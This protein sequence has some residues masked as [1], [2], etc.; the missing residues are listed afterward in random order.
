MKKWIFTGLGLFTIALLVFRPKPEPTITS[1]LSPTPQLQSISVKNVLLN[2]HLAKTNAEITKG[3]G[4]T[5][6]LP[7]NQGML[8]VFGERDQH[9]TF[10]MKDMVIPIDI[11]WIDENKIVQIDTNVQP[12][13]DP[14]KPETT[15]VPSHQPVDYVLEVNAGWSERNNVAVGDIVNLG[16]LN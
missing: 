13:V 12:P 15:L 8:F 1:A 9:H 4:E 2:I 7:E 14:S 10:W 11:I 5:Q 16:S 3:L 6:I